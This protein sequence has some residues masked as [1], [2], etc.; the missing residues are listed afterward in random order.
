MTISRKK[1]TLTELG[2]QFAKAMQIT[3]GMDP[4][5]GGNIDMSMQPNRKPDTKTDL[6]KKPNDRFAPPTKQQVKDSNA[7]HAR[8]KR[9]NAPGLEIDAKGETGKENKHKLTEFGKTVADACCGYM[10]KDKEKMISA[11]ASEMVDEHKR[12][13]QVLES[14]SHKDDK[15][16][17]KIQRKELKEYKAELGK[18]YQ[19]VSAEY[20]DGSGMYA[21][22]KNSEITKSM[23]DSWLCDLGDKVKKIA[24]FNKVAYSFEKKP[25]GSTDEYTFKVGDCQIVYKTMGTEAKI[26]FSQG[27]EADFR[28][29]AIAKTLFYSIKRFHSGENVLAKSEIEEDVLHPHEVK[30]KYASGMMADKHKA[31]VAEA[32][33]QGK[34]V[35]VHV[36][37]LPFGS[38]V[39]HMEVHHEDAKKSEFLK[40][41]TPGEGTSFP[42][43]VENYGGSGFERLKNKLKGTHE[44]H[45]VGE[46]VTVYRKPKKDNENLEHVATFHTKTGGLSHSEDF[47]KK[48]ESEL[49]KAGEGK[50]IVD[51]Y[52]SHKRETGGH[53][54]EH[55][56]TQVASW[57]GDEYG[58][59]RDKI[60][61]A[62]K[63]HPELKPASAGR[64]I[65]RPIK[66]FELT[67]M[68][69]EFAKALNK[70]AFQSPSKN[71]GS[72]KAG[73]V[74]AR[75][76]AE[77]E[78]P[79]FPHEA[80]SIAEVNSNAL[81]DAT[82]KL[83]KAPYTYGQQT[84]G[85][86]PKATPNPMAQQQQRMKQRIKRKFSGRKNTIV[87]IKASGRAR[88][89]LA[90]S[91]DL[92]A[93]GHE[94]V[95][96]MGKTPPAVK[97]K[98]PKVPSPKVASPS[99]GKSDI[100][101]GG[102]NMT[103]S[104]QGEP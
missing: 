91:E 78:I 93:L 94:F 60:H 89:F 30:R 22:F 73:K 56:A 98:A 3:K 90:R 72:M 97:P 1:P 75:L 41:R 74:G 80:R 66:K 29:V 39:R 40:T 104:G 95:K 31:T 18:S 25:V 81:K 17:A 28:N 100:V 71:S 96:A 37:H 20:P 101:A 69:E 58:M 59:E 27:K 10:K 16:E 99:V 62:M 26:T 84:A 42:H 19:V 9:H 5:G 61:Q 86:A 103:S 83:A 2:E 49:E 12:V 53:V 85:R 50:R 63:R 36:Q 32:E 11:P 77:K 21:K 47:L 6:I 65:I 24:E 23:G 57:H 64:F 52:I 4:M 33:K 14:P 88:G 51:A 92:T 13:V 70:G 7:H 46:H 55:H 8:I 87:D 82:K 79:L 35:K 34:K 76:K 67:F 54:G 102:S 68:G 15:Q 48:S 44:F 45:G 38:Y 43:H